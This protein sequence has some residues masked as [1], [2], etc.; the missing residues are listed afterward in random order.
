VKPL[1]WLTDEVSTPPFTPGAG[2][3]AGELIRLLRLGEHLGMPDSRPMPIIGRACHEL[4]VHDLDRDWRIFYHIG[5][6]AIVV[7]GVEKKTRQRTPTRIVEMCR[8]RL[9]VYFHQ[10]SA[11][12]P[13]R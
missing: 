12:R 6:D 5:P 13:I 7:L 2:A 11:G 4:R 1:V 3:N 8:R 10:R 9:R